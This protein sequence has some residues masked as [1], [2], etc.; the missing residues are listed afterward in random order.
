MAS[1]EFALIP[2]FISKVA[3]LSRPMH[4]HDVCIVNDKYNSCIQT[5]AT[6][7]PAPSPTSTTLTFIFKSVSQALTSAAPGNN[8]S[9]PGRSSAPGALDLRRVYAAPFQ[10]S[11]VAKRCA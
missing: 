5:G 3:N 10:V 2:E 9:R 1:Q 11:K 7:N 8:I 6:K 4:T